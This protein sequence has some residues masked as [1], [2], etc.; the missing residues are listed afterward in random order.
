MWQD[1][2]KDDFLLEAQDLTCLQRRRENQDVVRSEESDG[3]DSLP[4]KFHCYCR[5]DNQGCC[6]YFQL[7]FI[8]AGKLGTLAE[9]DERGHASAY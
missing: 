9:R 2:G 4:V 8:C 1:Q 7:E 5:K 3:V 6:T